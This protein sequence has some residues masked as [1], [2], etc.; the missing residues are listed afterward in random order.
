MK[1]QKEQKYLKSL[2]VFMNKDIKLYAIIE[3]I[4]EASVGKKPLRLK[5][6]APKSAFNSLILFSASPLCL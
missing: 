2:L 3:K 4:N 1:K 6:S 5:L